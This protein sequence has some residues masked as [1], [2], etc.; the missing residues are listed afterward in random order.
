MQ[1]QQLV[2]QGK[3]WQAGQGPVVE[4]TPRSSGY[5]ELDH[6]L[7]GG[8]PE[9]CLTELLC[10]QPGQGELSLLLPLLKQ[11]QCETPDHSILLVDP[12][13]LPCG[14][15][16]AG[17]GLKLPQLVTVQTRSRRDQLWTLEQALRSGCCPAVLSW[18]PQ[19]DARALRRLQVAATEGNSRGFLIRPLE[20][21]QSS[22]AAPW[23]LALRR[24]PDGVE[25]SLLKRKGGW[26]L[27]ARTLALPAHPLLPA[28][29]PPVTPPGA[30]GP[31]LRLVN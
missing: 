1:L 14:S 16:L 20:S 28:A 23:R 7:G 3:V 17:L 4:A 24:Q 12:P 9:A 31:A 13:L 11:L 21:L 8:W 29:Q 22:S 25:V 15:A 27:P 10:D 6:Y 5:P 19:A 30:T 2:Q 26:P 18:L